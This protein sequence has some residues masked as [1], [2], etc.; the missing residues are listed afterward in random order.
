MNVYNFYLT[1]KIAGKEIKDKITV[2]SK[3]KIKNVKIDECATNDGNNQD[4]K[5][6]LLIETDQSEKGISSMRLRES[7][8]GL[9]PYDKGRVLEKGIVKKEDVE[10]DNMDIFI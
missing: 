10:Y 4:I 9:S 2:K 8:Q 1:S 6:N 3:Y 5:S 7:F